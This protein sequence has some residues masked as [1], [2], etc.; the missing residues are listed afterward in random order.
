MNHD[1]LPT[2]APCVWVYHGA[3]A[4]DLYSEQDERS[5]LDLELLASPQCRFVSLSYSIDHVETVA[6]DMWDEIQGAYEE[7]HEC[8]LPFTVLRTTLSTKQV[9]R[10]A[11]FEGQMEVLEVVEVNYYLNQSVDPLMQVIVQKRPLR[12]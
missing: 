1:H 2:F 6:R 9:E 12:Q 3:T 4:E 5:E 11:G 7:A 10:P 8:G